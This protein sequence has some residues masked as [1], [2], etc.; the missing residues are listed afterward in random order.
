MNLIPILPVSKHRQRIRD[1]YIQLY[2]ASRNAENCGGRNRFQQE[3]GA[4]HPRTIEGSPRSTAYTLGFGS[5]IN[6]LACPTLRV[7]VFFPF[8]S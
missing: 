4:D 7:A 2:R 1:N 8:T 5:G 3:L 6:V